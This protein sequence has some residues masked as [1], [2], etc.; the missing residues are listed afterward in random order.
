MGTDPER[1]GHLLADE[2]LLQRAARH[3]HDEAAPVGGTS[4]S[5]DMR[6]RLRVFSKFLHGLCGI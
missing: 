5:T 1:R 3:L 6:D 2:L 4:G